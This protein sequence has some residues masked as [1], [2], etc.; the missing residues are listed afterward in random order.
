MTAQNMGKKILSEA[1]YDVVAVSN[2]AAAVKK[3]AERKP[4]LAVLDVYMPGYTGLEVCERVKTALETSAM[5]V[6]LTVGRMEP[7][8]P[9]EGTRVRADGI[10]VKPFEAQDLLSA[11]QKLEQ[12]LSLKGKIVAT[13]TDPAELPEYERTVKIAAPVF[14]EHDES[15]QA[16][17]SAESD[18]PAQVKVPTGMQTAPAF[19][20]ELGAPEQHV[21]SRY[22]APT[23][24]I[25]PKV[26]L[27]PAPAEAT[28]AD[29]PAVDEA[30]SSGVGKLLSKAKEWFGGGS[31][32][33]AATPAFADEELT[34]VQPSEPA[35]D[36]AQTIRVEPPSAETV[37]EFERV[38]SYGATEAPA[39]AAPAEAAAP[40]MSS[41]AEH[42]FA[43]TVGG[44]PEELSAAAF[45]PT[46]SEPVEV[47]PSAAPG[48][49]P[50][51]VPATEQE[52]ETASASGFEPTSARDETEVAA[53]GMDSQLITD[54]SEMSTAFPTKFGVEGAE[55]VHVGDA[56]QFPALYTA[57]TTEEQAP[58]QPTAELAAPEPQAISESDFDQKVAAAM[59]TSWAAEEAPLEEHERGTTLHEEMQQQLGQAAPAPEPEPDSAHVHVEAAAAPKENEP[60]HELAAAMAAAVGSQIEP[61]VAQAVE[62]T[63]AVGDSTQS[64]DQHTAVIAEIVQR[65]TERIKP[66]LI[67]QITRELAELKK[68]KS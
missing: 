61:V 34:P 23:E 18:E 2:G 9:E 48:F 63:A 15:Y 39:Q 56:S 16:W 35:A 66:E 54:V 33:E 44:A 30:G 27:Q 6:L 31:A 64:M 14:D 3:I 57:P 45:E 60:D 46:A 4:D 59:E 12:R 47:A 49:E 67:E 42:F 50:T 26:I 13:P 37:A 25:E 58:E 52:H 62:Q 10:I 24:P 29:A 19:A 65:V 11:V 53:G 8:K 68:K 38:Q 32:E 36:Y 1:G 7:F 22:T 17:K 55:P 5:P 43:A 41:A 51:S 28:A 40:A 21:T 20:D